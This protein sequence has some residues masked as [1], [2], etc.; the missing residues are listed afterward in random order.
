MTF[1]DDAL[2]SYLWTDLIDELK[3]YFICG[4][5]FDD[6]TRGYHTLGGQSSL[7]LN[8]AFVHMHNQK[9]AKTMQKK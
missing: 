7:L 5:K 8:W 9:N 1:H 6:V 2:G 4:G 3:Y